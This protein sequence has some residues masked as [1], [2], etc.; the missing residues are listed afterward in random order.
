MKNLA[1]HKKN[2][3]TREISVQAIYQL[4]FDST[5]SIKKIIKQFQEENSPKR[6]NFQMFSSY[7]QEIKNKESYLNA[8]F[9]KLEINDI[10][11]ID[12]AIIFLGIIELEQ[13]KFPKE[14]TF[15]ECIRLARKFSNPESYKF[16]NACL[17]KFSKLN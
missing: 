12:K 2:I 5:I 11:L 4:L 8:I 17:D 7:V 9:E 16:I 15:D 14:V 10:D 13:E 6:V 1:K 3:Q